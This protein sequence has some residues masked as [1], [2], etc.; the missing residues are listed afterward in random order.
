MPTTKKTSRKPTMDGRTEW[1]LLRGWEPFRLHEVPAER[2]EHPVTHYCL[3]GDER[4]TPV[5]ELPEEKRAGLRR[6]GK[7]AAGAAAK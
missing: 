2:R 5:D 1:V 3:E 4:W 6:L 7:R